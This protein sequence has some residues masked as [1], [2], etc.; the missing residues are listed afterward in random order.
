MKTPEVF[1][2]H[3]SHGH[4]VYHIKFVSTTTES[5]E[6][7]IQIHLWQEQEVTVNVAHATD[8]EVEYVEAVLVKERLVVGELVRIRVALEVKDLIE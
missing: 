6:L 1:M 2:H 8:V 7:I 4:L 5:Q 3:C